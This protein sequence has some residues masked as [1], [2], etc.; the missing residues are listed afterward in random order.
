MKRKQQFAI[1][2]TVVLRLVGEALMDPRTVSRRVR[3]E[4]GHPAFDRQ[5]EQAAEK[6]GIKLSPTD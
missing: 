1:D 6:L 3:G 4:R 5:I 2:R